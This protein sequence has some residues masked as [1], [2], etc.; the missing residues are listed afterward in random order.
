MTTANEIELKLLL[1]PPPAIAPVYKRARD[2]GVLENLR[3]EQSARQWRCG[4]CNKMQPIGSW[5]VWVPEGLQKSDPIWAFVEAAKE[6]AYNGCKG[7]WCTRCAPKQ[8]NTD[9]TKGIQKPRR[10][11]KWWM[12]W[13]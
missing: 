3:V 2:I 12:I 10:K 13:P 4:W 5:L 6:G 11:R 9:S 1:E 7:A 8:S